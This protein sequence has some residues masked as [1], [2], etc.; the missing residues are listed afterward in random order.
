M[1][2]RPFRGICIFSK[3]RLEASDNGKKTSGFFKS[4]A[5][6]GSLQNPEIIQRQHKQKYNTNGHTEKQ[7]GCTWNHSA[8]E[9]CSEKDEIKGNGW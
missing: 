5:N 8:E 3:Q 2:P 4:K 1:Q 7:I 6:E 9:G